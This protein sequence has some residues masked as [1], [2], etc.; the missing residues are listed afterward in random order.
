MAWHPNSL[1]KEHQSQMSTD[2]SYLSTAP[3]RQRL[4]RLWGCRLLFTAILGACSLVLFC[5]ASESQ[6]I[7]VSHVVE[8]SADSQQ[9][10]HREVIMAADP[11]D[12]RR[13]LACSMVQPAQPS[14]Q[15]SRDAA[16]LSVDGGLHWVKTLE[17]G[18]ALW[19]SDPSCA[20]SANGLALYAGLNFDPLR[21][22]W[23]GD[24]VLYT[25]A[26]GGA[27]WVADPSLPQGDRE[28]ITT[29]PERDRIYMGEIVD[30]LSL[31]G[32]K[33]APLVVYESKDGG[34]SFHV[35]AVLSAAR[36]IR[37][38]G[39]PGGVLP[40]GRFATAF[41][42]IPERAALR[43]TDSHIAGAVRIFLY[44]AELSPR[45]VLPVVN[46][47]HECNAWRNSTPMP[48]LAVDESG[49]IFR[50]RMYVAWPDSRSGRC[51]ILFASS[52]D[53][54][55]TWSAP[56]R[57]NDDQA[58]GTKDGGPDDFHPVVSV[59]SYGV[60]GVLWYDRRND[61][62][63]VS[64]QPR[65]SASLDGGLTFRPS[66]AFEGAGMK[67]YKSKVA[68]L[69]FAV[70]GGDDPP[71]RSGGP[72]RV[73]FGYQSPELTG[74]ETAGLAADRSG[75]FHALWID[76]R[77]GVTQVWT[78]Q[79][80][81]AGRVASNSSP[82][83]QQ[84]SD[85]SNKVAILFAH[86]KLD[87]ANHIFTVDAYLQNTSHSTIF[88]PVEL[89]TLSLG[90][91][92]GEPQLTD[93]DNRKTGAGAVFNFSSLV[94]HSGLCP[95]QRTAAKKIVVNLRHLISKVPPG[96]YK[97]LSQIVTIEFS[98]FGEIGAPL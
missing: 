49:G 10:N 51:D 79:I 19:S 84:L 2:N 42:V 61:P 18:G 53:G 5:R 16:Y 46:E 77:S 81:I 72:V 4:R 3:V 39:Y 56:V 33:K 26:N 50:G 30:G 7:K 52:S 91:E 22:Q 94:P 64:W 34:R 83:S 36:Q 88:A 59:S 66:V 87:R 23:T 86:P 28:F 9:Q 48:S 37:V 8:V 73:S 65:F 1:G 35:G 78:A 45:V 54:G 97:T 75:L 24:T 70:R 32:T 63:N 95:G 21:S 82:P 41:S 57:V 62:D 6:E 89:M 71:F 25:S 69:G 43:G 80:S 20:F 96:D 12:P 67:L 44:D 38:F 27:T 14:M 13:L 17:F 29:D 93:A 47:L 90:S 58:R 11:S 68:H 85:L 31:D 40:D 98:V 92:V 55:K 60:V 76:N 74:G 15:A